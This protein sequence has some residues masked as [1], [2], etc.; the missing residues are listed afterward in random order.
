[1]SLANLVLADGQ[2]TPANHTFSEVANYPLAEWHEKTGVAIGEPKIVIGQ[3]R[4][5]KKRRSQK[6]TIRIEVPVLK[7]VTGS[8]GGYT[9]APAVDFTMFA[10]VD[11]VAPDRS[12]LSQRKDLYAF[13]K[14]LLAEA[15]VKSMFVD[16]APA[17]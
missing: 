14:N 8:D 11:L 15:M 1:M 4:P 6:T 5:S 9:P 2:T 7:A 3:S 13:V 10:A 16:Q 12:T 17:A